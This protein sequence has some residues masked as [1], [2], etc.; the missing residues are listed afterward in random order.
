MYFHTKVQVHGLHILTYMYMIIYVYSIPQSRTY[1]ERWKQRK[2]YMYEL[3]G[4]II[5]CFTR[6]NIC[7]CTSFEENLFTC[8][9]SSSLVLCLVSFAFSRR[10]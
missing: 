3:S 7:L 6:V 4:L 5:S 1:S 10:R 9:I 2:K 8:K